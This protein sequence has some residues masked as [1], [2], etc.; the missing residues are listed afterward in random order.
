KNDYETAKST[1][2]F[3]KEVGKPAEENWMIN[4]LQLANSHRQLD[5]RNG[6]HTM[7]SFGTKPSG[8]DVTNYYSAEIFASERQND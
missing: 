3:F 2:L 7:V 8:W 5:K 4:A 6:L 1:E